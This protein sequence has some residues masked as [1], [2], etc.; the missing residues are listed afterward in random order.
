MILVFLY[1]KNTLKSDNLYFDF[2]WKKI[3]TGFNVIYL[4]PSIFFI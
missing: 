1:Y 3:K 2:M 4:H